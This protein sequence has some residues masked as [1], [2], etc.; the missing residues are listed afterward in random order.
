MSLKQ[1]INTSISQLVLS[2]C[3][4]KKCNKI[5]KVFRNNTN[6]IDQYGHA[7]Q[8]VYRLNNDKYVVYHLPK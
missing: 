4:M 8:I 2:H 6:N 3:Y 7:L 5:D 1:L